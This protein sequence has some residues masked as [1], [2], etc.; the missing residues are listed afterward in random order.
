MRVLKP[1][2][3]NPDVE[4]EFL[5]LDAAETRGEVV[6]DKWRV[7]KG[8]FLS[9]I[10]RHET[11]KKWRLDLD[12]L[13]LAIRGWTYTGKSD[14]LRYWPPLTEKKKQKI[15]HILFYR[16][17]WCR[18]EV[19]YFSKK[20]MLEDLFEFHKENSPRCEPYPKALERERE[21]KFAIFEE[22]TRK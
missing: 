11:F 14:R 21:E 19:G 2:Q 5:L 22:R 10:F 4:G 8:R 17:E 7:E 16:C 20:D 18:M 1:P 15:G 13:T 3:A 9:P 6:P 12:S